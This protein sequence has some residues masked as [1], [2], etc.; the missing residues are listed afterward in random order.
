MEIIHAIILGIIQ[1]ITEWLPISSSGHLAL[2]QM[3]FNLEVPVLFNVML[4]VAT[5]LVILVVFNKDI[6]KCLKALR[7]LDFKSEYGKL[8]KFIIIGTV[9]I[10]VIGKIN[11]NGMN[12]VVC[13]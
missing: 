1:G 8:N 7:K 9:P 5:L 12:V 3:L 4:H 13:C 2:A 10:A 11:S 6:I